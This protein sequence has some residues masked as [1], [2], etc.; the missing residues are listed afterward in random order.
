M[1]IEATNARDLVVPPGRKPSGGQLLRELVELFR[2]YSK[3][4]MALS[5]GLNEVSTPT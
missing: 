1:V 2:G 5:A 3:G 4:R